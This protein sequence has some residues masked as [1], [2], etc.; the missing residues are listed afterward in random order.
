[1]VA[2][3]VD[4][5]LFQGEGVGQDQV[6]DQG[7]AIAQGDSFIVADGGAEG[8]GFSQGDSVGQVVAEGE[9][10]RLNETF[11]VEDV[12]NLVAV[13]AEVDRFGYREGVSQSQLICVVFAEVVDDGEQVID[14]AVDVNLGQG[15]FDVKA[16]RQVLDVIDNVSEVFVILIMQSDDIAEIVG[17]ALNDAISQNRRISLVTI[18]AAGDAFRNGE[19]VGLVTDPGFGNGIENSEA[20]GLFG[21]C[22]LGDRVSDREDVSMVAVGAEVDRINHREGVSEVMNRAQGDSIA[23]G[24]AVAQGQEVGFVAVQEIVDDQDVVQVMDGA[25]DDGVEQGEQVE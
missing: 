5:R 8:E 19:A 1:M 12:V 13:G 4:Q 25:L 18:C 16:V 23:Q 20:V 14:V 9:G 15:V 10:Q 22:G 3:A 21:V 7:V 6:G 17:G 24:D 11:L 2:D